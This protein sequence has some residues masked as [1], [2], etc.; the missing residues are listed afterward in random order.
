MLLT[1]QEVEARLNAVGAFW[2][3]QMDDQ[4]ELWG[5]AWGFHLWVPI[6]DPKALLDE[7][8]VREIEA[9]IRNSKP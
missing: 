3:T 4:H 6:A 2:L 1:K 9:E 5:T 8:D 7:E